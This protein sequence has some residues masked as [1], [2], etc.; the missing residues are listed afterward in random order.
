MNSPY[1][2]N[3]FL[4]CWRIQ[5]SAARHK[6]KELADKAASFF[7]TLSARRPLART[8]YRPETKDPNCRQN[9]NTPKTGVQYSKRLER[10]MQ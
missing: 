9:K 8:T 6:S 7:F 2:L 1:G 5:E 10:T 3:S 4:P